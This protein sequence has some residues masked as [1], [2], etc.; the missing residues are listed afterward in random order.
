MTNLIELIPAN[1]KSKEDIDF[2]YKIL[3]Y[4]WKYKDIIN[5]K[6]KTP[7]KTP[8]YEDHL[9][10]LKSSKYKGIYKVYLYN[11]LVGMVYLDNNDF[12]GTFLMPSF[13][14]KA[15]KKLKN[16]NI[17]IDKELITPQIHIQ[18][19]KL[20]P[21]VKIVYAAVNP[22]NHLSLNALIHNGYEPI[23]VVL[24]ITSENGQP[25]QGKWKPI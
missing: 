8:T 10:N 23:E 19:L 9:K 18:L 16:D 17:E 1:I 11:Q 4:R 7:D 13:L 22:K 6:Y 14:K 12:N 25:S 24:A 3:L 21:E 15:F 2:L 20:H 5:I